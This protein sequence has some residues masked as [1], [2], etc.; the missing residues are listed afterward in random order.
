M[1]NS[2]MDLFRFKGLNEEL[3]FVLLLLSLST[4]VVFTGASFVMLL[5]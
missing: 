1:G 5:G 4:W 2:T 3:V